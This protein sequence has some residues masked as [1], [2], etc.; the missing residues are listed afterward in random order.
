M[1]NACKSGVKRKRYTV[2]VHSVMKPIFFTVLV[3]VTHAS[4]AVVC[5]KLVPVDVQ[6]GVYL[7]IND[8]NV[9]MLL[10]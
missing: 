1:R 4:D 2:P 3:S 6:K 8:T 9:H 7:R 5:L 10:I